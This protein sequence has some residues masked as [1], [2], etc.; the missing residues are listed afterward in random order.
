MDLLLIESLHSGSERLARLVD[1]PV[2]MVS[3]CNVTQGL[4]G[5]CR[6]EHS[7]KLV[8]LEERRFFLQHL[9]HVLMLKQGVAL[10]YKVLLIKLLHG[11]AV[12]IENVIVTHSASLHKF[13]TLLELSGQ[14]CFI[15]FGIAVEQGQFVVGN[16]YLTL[17]SSF[18]KNLGEE[19]N[20]VNIIK[21]TIYNLPW[22]SQ[23]KISKQYSDF[24]KKRD[25]IGDKYGVQFG[26]TKY[27]TST[28]NFGT[29]GGIQQYAGNNADLST[30][31]YSNFNMSGIKPLSTEYY[32]VMDNGDLRPISIDRLTLLPYKPKD[33]AIDR[34]RAAGATD[35][36]IQP[37]LNMQYQRFEHSHVL[38]VSATP[39][40]G[41][42]T[43]LINNKLSDKI[44]GISG[45]KTENIIKLAQDRYTRFTDKDVRFEKSMA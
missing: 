24:K 22:Q 25:E 30:H 32:M 4:V 36:D 41:I 17:V 45:V 14:E 26:T 42:P 21:L 12:D 13:R 40:T 34:L 31:T 19:G 43:L 18:A 10:H 5:T 7:L 28:N 44:G 11:H 15:A 1:L 37:L 8:N 33:S 6:I 9:R 2:E 39:D 20:L 35:A 27:G 38:F 16:G 23:D 29:K 3:Q